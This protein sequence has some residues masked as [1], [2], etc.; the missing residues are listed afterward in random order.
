MS[1][2]VMVFRTLNRQGIHLILFYPG[3]GAVN[4][5]MYDSR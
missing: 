4:F 3:F 2:G 5:N 1:I